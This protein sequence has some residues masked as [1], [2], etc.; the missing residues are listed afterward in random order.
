MAAEFMEGSVLTR[1][2]K[3]YKRHH[4][5]FNNFRETLQECDDPGEF[6]EYC[7]NDIQR[8]QEVVL[9]I[10]YLYSVRGYRGS[11]ITATLCG[12]GYCLELLGVDSKFLHTESSRRA[13]RACGRNPDEARE[14]HAKRVSR[15]KDPATGTILQHVRS[16]Y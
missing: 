10:K 2:S 14:H 9:F 1:T 12:L 13:I 11:S 3:D 4:A 16:L 15:D 8:T 5:V 6:F 7:H